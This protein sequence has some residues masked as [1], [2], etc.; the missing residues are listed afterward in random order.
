MILKNFL[1]LSHTQGI[2]SQFQAS[3][4]L[5]NMEGEDDAEEDSDLNQSDSAGDGDESAGADDGES[6]EDDTET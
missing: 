1:C 5:N 6:E 3:L 4:L 2:I